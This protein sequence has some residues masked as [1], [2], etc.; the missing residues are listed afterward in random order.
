M[1]EMFDIEGIVRREDLDRRHQAIV[2]RRR[3]IIFSIIGV[4]ALFV[5]FLVLYH[6]TN[7]MFGVSKGLE[8]APQNGDWPVFRYD[9]ANTGSAGSEDISPNGTLKWSFSAGDA[10]HSSPAVVNGVVY[11]G[12]RDHYLYALDAETGQQ[13]WSFETGSWV[14][15]SPAVVDG[16]VYCGSNDG[17]LYALDAATGT[18]LWRFYAKY[19]VRSSP[20]VADGIVYVG[21]DDYHLYAVDTRTGKEVWNLQAENFVISSPVVTD[22][23]VVVGSMDGAFYALNAENGRHRLEFQLGI[24]I[25]SSPAIYDGTA[26]VTTA[27]HLIAIDTKAR[28]WLLENK[29]SVYWRVLYVYGIAPKP[30]VP[31]GFLWSYSLG[32]GKKVSSSPA[33]LDGNIYLASDNIIMSMHLEERQVNWQFPASDWIVSSPAVTSTAVYFGSYDGHLY[34]L[35]RATGARLWDYQ[36]GDRITSSPAVVDGVVYVGSE[37]GVF[38]AFK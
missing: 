18:E 17:N 14:E 16:V 12:S 20:A 24:A 13:I 32:F 28:N 26:Y 37:D 2:K 5:L 7:I 38:Y 36:T 31:S 22:G 34:A 4:I 9:Q 15:S 19:P 3:I 11:F 21:S 8:S 35:D 25:V 10:I 33:I 23:I 29:L 30:P 27:G 1:P 6:F